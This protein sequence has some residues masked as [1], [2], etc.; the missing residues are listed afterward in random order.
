MLSPRAL[1]NMNNYYDGV[2]IV[3][4]TLAV[5]LTRV[6][7]SFQGVQLK[8]YSVVLTRHQLFIDI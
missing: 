7:K 4:C 1:I 3:Y 6:S 5:L 8:I 2:V